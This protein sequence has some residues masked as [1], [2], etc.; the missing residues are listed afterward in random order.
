MIAW[1]AQGLEKVVPQPELNRKESP[2]AEQP[3]EVHQL[4]LQD[5]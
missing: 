1:I 3:A 2:P 4:L 5:V